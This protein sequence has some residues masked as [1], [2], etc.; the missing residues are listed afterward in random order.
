MDE[1]R[2]QNKN[3]LPAFDVDDRIGLHIEVGLARQLGLLILESPTPNSALL[4]LGHQLRN[5]T[6]ARPDEEL[7]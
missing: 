7:L 3:I 4:A 1:P 2:K 6:D 5:L